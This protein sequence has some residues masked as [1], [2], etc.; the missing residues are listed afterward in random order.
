MKEFISKAREELLAAV[1]NLSDQQL[2]FVVEEGTWSIMQV[3]EHLYLIEKSVA[4]GLAKEVEKEHGKQTEEKPIHLTPIRKKRVDAPAF[5]IPSNDFVPL[6]AMKRKLDG[7][8][9]AL[10]QAIAGVD[11]ETLQSKSMP[12]MVFGDLNLKQWVEFIGFHEQRHL[13]QIKEV[14]ERLIE[15]N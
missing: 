8:R 9:D 2:N 15:W 7:S 3:L 10:L 13:E 4:K 1:E 14:K 12:H 11:E 6:I 5:S